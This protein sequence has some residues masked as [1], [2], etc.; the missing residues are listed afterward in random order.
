MAE[1][2]ASRWAEMVI[3]DA[4]SAADTAAEDAL[5]RAEA[6][7]DASVIQRKTASRSPATDNDWPL[8]PIKESA[9][10]EMAKQFQP[11]LHPEPKAKEAATHA[12]PCSNELPT[13]NDFIPDFRKARS[14]SPER[15]R[16]HDVTKL[17]VQADL[18]EYRLSMLQLDIGQI[19][20]RIQQQSGGVAASIA[21]T[22]CSHLDTELT[23]MRRHHEQQL[24]QL[25]ALLRR[26]FNME[27]PFAVEEA[28][29]SNSIAAVAAASLNP[30]KHTIVMPESAQRDAT[31]ASGMADNP[32]SCGRLPVSTAAPL[33]RTRE[34]QILHRTPQSPVQMDS[35]GLMSASQSQ[36]PCRF[37]RDHLSPALHIRGS[38]SASLSECGTRVDEGLNDTGSPTHPLS[39]SH[40]TQGAGT[41]TS[42]LTPRNVSSIENARAVTSPWKSVPQ[43]YRELP[44]EVSGTAEQHVSLE[45]PAH[46][47]TVLQVP[48]MRGSQ[49]SQEA[50]R[51][52][53]CVPTV[54]PPPPVSPLINQRHSS[55]ALPTSIGHPKKQG[56]ASVTCLPGHP[57]K[58]RGVIS[59]PLCRETPIMRAEPL[60]RSTGGESMA[61]WLA[62][63]RFDSMPHG[64]AVRG[65]PGMPA[66]EMRFPLSDVGIAPRMLSPRGR[67]GTSGRAERFDEDSASPPK[68][69]EQSRASFAA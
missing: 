39:I 9:V 31:P 21:S 8:D 23:K 13:H 34:H 22:V 57:G 51:T 67:D 48:P 66:E 62:K 44:H 12:Y 52:A 14:A 61:Q 55:A 7:R 6:D 20:T 35:R 54:A 59:V 69:R 64:A 16:D 11:A 15:P 60:R 46:S 53:R 19:S 56:S 32:H 30:S 4:I 28:T 33:P 24:N 65:S 45:R 37:D 47:T 38:A 40:S 25:S 36:S 63:V 42:W 58:R 49:S 1:E 10:P 41:N 43:R 68:S 27:L 29:C 3:A 17:S 26:A 50:P 18:I 5:S 2:A